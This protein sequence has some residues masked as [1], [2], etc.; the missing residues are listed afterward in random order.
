MNIPE[1]IPIKRIEDYHTHFVGYCDNNKQFWGYG[2]FVFDEPYS[3]IDRS[4]WQEHRLEYIVL[5]TFDILGNHLSTKH[6]FVGTTANRI[7]DSDETIL[8]EWLS[9]FAEVEFKDINVKPFQTVIDGYVFG[10]IP[11][12]N[13]DGLELQPSSTIF[14]QEPWDGEYDT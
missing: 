11:T 7:E 9:K 1:K 2:T 6:L 3:E 13:S 10:L 12:L 14:F 8:S 4:R 5:H